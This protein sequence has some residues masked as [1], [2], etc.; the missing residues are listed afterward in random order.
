VEIKV[1]DLG[2]FD[3]VEI[4]EVLVRPGDTVA[5][6]DPLVTLETEKAATMNRFR[7]AIAASASRMAATA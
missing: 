6:D 1:P 2:D 7:I 5:V 3:E 4:I